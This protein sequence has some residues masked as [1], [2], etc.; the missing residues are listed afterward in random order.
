MTDGKFIKKGMEIFYKKDIH[1]M[2]YIAY[3]IPSKRAPNERKARMAFY[4]K[5]NLGKR[6]DALERRSQKY[7]TVTSLKASV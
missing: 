5:N 2:Y 1:G 3:V 7:R 4:K 6:I